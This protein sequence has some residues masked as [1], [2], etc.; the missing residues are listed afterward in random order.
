MV[1]TPRAEITGDAPAVPKVVRFALGHLSL[2][3]I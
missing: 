2:I 1:H 3:F